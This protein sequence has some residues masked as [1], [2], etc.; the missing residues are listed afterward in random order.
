MPTPAD[1]TIAYS[2]RFGHKR[3]RPAREVGHLPFETFPH[4]DPPFAYRGRQSVVTDGW[5]SST[6]ASTSLASLRQHRV[7]LELDRDRDID[8]FS[9]GPIELRWT[10]EDGRRQT[11]RP[12]FIARARDGQRLV[13][14]IAPD[15]V[16]A[17]WHATV[18]VVAEAARQAGWGLRTAEVPKGAPLANLLRAAQARDPRRRDPEQARAV[19]DAFPAPRILTEAVAG[20]GLPRLVALDVAWHLIWTGRLGIDWDCVFVPTRSLAWALE[21]GR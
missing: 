16:D 20:C 10:C 5:V 6:G 7:A 11:L 2:E 1:I 12:P 3:E 15:A 14:L 17:R 21:E 9:A 8:A 19:L 13:V 4:P 18:Q